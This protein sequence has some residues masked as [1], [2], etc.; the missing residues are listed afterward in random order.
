M[1]AGTFASPHKFLIIT[2]KDGAEDS[3]N[4]IFSRDPDRIAEMQAARTSALAFTAAQINDPGS[5]CEPTRLNAD[6]CMTPHYAPLMQLWN[7]GHMSVT[8]QVG[9]MF[10]PI[11]DT[12]RATLQLAL[13]NPNTTGIILPFGIG[14]HDTMA[15][16]MGSMVSVDYVD[17]SGRGW[18]RKNSGWGGRLAEE[19]AAFNAAAA[20]PMLN[21][22]G[23]GSTFGAVWPKSQSAKAL[24]LPGIG[25]PFGMGTGTFPTQMLARI[26]AATASARAE[27]RDEYSRSAYLQTVEGTG[28]WGPIVSTAR[29]GG[30]PAFAVDA[31]FATPAGN[32]QSWQGGFLQLARAIERRVT[33]S[34]PNI[35]WRSVFTLSYG[36]WDTHSNQGLLSTA[37]STG[38]VRLQLDYGKGLREFRDAMFALDG[39]GELWDSILVL[40]MSEFARTIRINGGNGTDHAWA[41]TRMMFGG[42]VRGQGVGGSTG[43]FGS[44][45][46]S[47]GFFG[48]GSDDIFGSAI[49]AGSLPPRVSW[50][51]WLD[52]A[53]RWFG[54]DNDDIAEILPRRALHPASPDLIV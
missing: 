47:L 33:A 30:G 12:P 37:A 28:H 16:A 23:G 39:T 35:P 45:P 9:A 43:F 50:E 31:S 4:T 42:A 13:A 17:G 2:N 34:T 54:C 21:Q 22:F 24:R 38:L 40:D 11:H 29:G 10:T 48:S 8:G 20:L 26:A 25:Q 1:P 32:S 52:P 44:F 15:T 53:L 14:G 7:D 51:Q 41:G 49:G 5:V 18:T 46:T 19:Y 6:W 36:G 27:A 3:Y